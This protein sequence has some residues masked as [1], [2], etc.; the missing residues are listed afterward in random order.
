MLSEL[1]ARF[2]AERF[3]LVHAGRLYVAE[4]ALALDASRTLD[5]DEDDAWSWSREAELHREAGN[6]DAADW[7]DAEAEAETR[8]LARTAGD[9]AATF[10][11]GP[12]DRD[13]IA[14]RLPGLVPTVVPNSVPFPANPRRSD[15]GRTLLFVGSL[16]YAPNVEGLRWFVA[17]VLPQVAAHAAVRLR[18]VGRNAPPS[19]LAL[20]EHPLVEFVGEVDAVTP[21]YETATLAL[22]PLHSGGGTRIKLVEAA[23]HHVPIVSTTIG[24]QGLDLTDSM[25]WRADTPAAF[26]AAII[27][28]LRDPL[29]RERRTHAAHA[30]LRA[31]SDRDHIITTLACR[32]EGIIAKAR[33]HES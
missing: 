6:N 25:I 16:G 27:E 31:T 17:E 19:V 29:D 30:H 33:A 4:A 3:D 1:R 23:A 18:I 28:A 14:A 24:A 21:A 22:A 15:D 8:L 20:G 32:F 5:L 11:A 7:A 10:I 9:F 13:R 2:G 26:A 12:A